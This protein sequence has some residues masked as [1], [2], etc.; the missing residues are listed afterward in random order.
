MSNKIFKNFHKQD[1]NKIYGR[2]HKMAMEI[3]KLVINQMS[4]GTVKR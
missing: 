3:L 2:G 4:S 1:E